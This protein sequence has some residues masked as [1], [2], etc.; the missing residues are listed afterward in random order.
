LQQRQVEYIQRMFV[1]ATGLLEISV[2]LERRP[3]LAW[4]ADAVAH[5]MKAEGGATWASASGT[6]VTFLGPARFR[7]GAIWVPDRL[8]LV[9]SGELRFAWS[10]PRILVSY[11]LSYRRFLLAALGLAGV[12]TAAIAY[13][14]VA[15]PSWLAAVFL[16]MYLA[17]AGVSV[18]GSVVRVRRFL[19]RTVSRSV[20]AEES[21]DT[22]SP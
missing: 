4:L 19:R 3:H 9:T 22:A 14:G 10:P 11:E 5:A 20:H 15:R 12:A 21:A 1:G 8:H 18:L 17:I 16:G 2:R 7:L 13:A 6:R